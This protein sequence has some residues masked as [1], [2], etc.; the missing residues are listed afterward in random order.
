ML[1]GLRAFGAI[2]GGLMGPRTWVLKDREAGQ[3]V[4]S[5]KIENTGFL[6][7]NM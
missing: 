5:F 7:L 6:S 1:R 4:E 3:A 2:S